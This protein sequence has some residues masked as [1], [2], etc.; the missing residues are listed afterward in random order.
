MMFLLELESALDLDDFGLIGLNYTRFGEAVLVQLDKPP[1]GKFIEQKSGG[2]NNCITVFSQNYKICDIIWSAA[3]GAHF[4]KNV[5]TVVHRD[6]DMWNDGIW[7]LVLYNKTDQSYEEWD[8]FFT[9]EDVI[10]LETHVDINS[11]KRFLEVPENIKCDLVDWIL[12]E[13][14][15]KRMF[16]KFLCLNGQV[17]FAFK[18]ITFDGEGRHFCKNT[19]RLLPVCHVSI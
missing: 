15:I 12:A 19:T 7:N 8:L 2:R 6:S 5:Y 16:V 17:S 14:F 1:I 10:Y 3:C 13:N 18:L 9:S 11:L 4:D